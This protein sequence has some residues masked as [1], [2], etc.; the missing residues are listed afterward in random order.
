MTRSTGKLPPQIKHTTPNDPNVLPI[1]E[2][3]QANRDCYWDFWMWLKDTGYSPVTIHAYKIGARFALG[4]LKKPYW[5]IDPQIDL[6]KTLAYIQDMYTDSNRPVHYRKGIRKFG[7][8][9]QI[10]LG[11]PPTP[12]PINWPYYFQGLPKEIAAGIGEYFKHRQRNWKP[13]HQHESGLNFLSHLT[14]SLRWMA[15]HWKLDSLTDITPQ[16]WYAYLDARLSRGISPVSLNGELRELFGFLQFAQGA[17]LPLCERF[18]KVELL[19][20]GPHLPKDVPIQQVRILMAEIEREVQAAKDDRRRLGLMDRAWFLLMLHAGLRTGEIRSLRFEH[21]DLANRRVRIEQSKM[22]KD[23]LVYFSQA[24]AEALSAYLAVRGAGID[25]P[26]QVFIYRHQPLSRSYC[27]QRLRTYAKRCGVRVSP[28]QLRHTCATLLLNERVPVL[29][30]QMILGHQHVDT[31]MRYARL[32]DGTLAEDYFRAMD[33]IE[34]LT[35]SV[36]APASTRERVLAQLEGLQQVLERPEQK[37]LV[38]SIQANI[39]ELLPTENIY[40][41]RDW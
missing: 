6:E 10:N 36:E 39:L 5:A 18:F 29:S 28:H 8:Y 15:V 3:P 31:T 14:L 22:L 41:N 25:L 21:L 20:T 35:Q 40:P 38:A 32:Y 4:F 11:I 16:A 17:G 33:Q 12:K 23:R 30:V 24:A 26:P 13:E 1:A 19:P 27:Y 34:G 9:L 2:W 7:Q 37:A